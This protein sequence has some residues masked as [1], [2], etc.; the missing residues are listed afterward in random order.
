MVHHFK[1]FYNQNKIQI[2]VVIT[3]SQYNILGK[4]AAFIPSEFYLPSIVKENI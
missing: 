2:S 3:Y 1:G 4:T